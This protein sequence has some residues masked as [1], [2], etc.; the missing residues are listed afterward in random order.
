MVNPTTPQSP[1]P[2]PQPPRLVGWTPM[3][4]G[5]LA[6]VLGGLWTLQGIGVVGGSVMSGNRI[7]AIIGPVV[8]LAGLI[9]IVIG[10]RR[11]NRHRRAAGQNQA[12]QGQAGQEQAGQ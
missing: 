7:W 3:V 1:E 5:L 11:R 8:A 2:Q 10:T 4:I 9:L 12:G 6:I